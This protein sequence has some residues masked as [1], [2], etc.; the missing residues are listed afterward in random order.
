VFWLGSK[1]TQEEYTLICNL[2]Q[3]NSYTFLSISNKQSDAVALQSL[4]YPTYNQV[5]QVRK[6]KDAS[7]RPVLIMHSSVYLASSYGIRSR[8]I[9]HKNISSCQ[10]N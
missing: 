3:I 1:S 5:V 6:D 4:D 10:K 9:L 8:R 2:V 7:R